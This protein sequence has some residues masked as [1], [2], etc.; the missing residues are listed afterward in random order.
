VQGKG[1][2][3]R[4]RQKEGVR[5]SGSKYVLEDLAMPE[6]MVPTDEICERSAGG[7]F[8]PIKNPV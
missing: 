2:L 6:F 7:S 8:F 4:D 1:G 3:H 5:I